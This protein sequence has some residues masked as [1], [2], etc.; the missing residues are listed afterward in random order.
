MAILRDLFAR[1]S[2]AK[3]A[4]ARKSVEILNAIIGHMI[5]PMFVLDREGKVTIWNE[6]CER[7]TGLPRPRS[8]APRCIGRAFISAAPLSCRSRLQ[9]RR[10]RSQK[11][12]RHAR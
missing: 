5:V 1:R 2:A 8:W 4:A 9:G 7:L 3:P 6:A 10:R 11:A 12:L